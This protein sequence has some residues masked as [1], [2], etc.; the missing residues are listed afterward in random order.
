MVWEGIFRKAA[1]VE[2][3]GTDREYLF[4]VAK[5]RYVGHTFEV[6]GIAVHTFDQVI[7][8]HM[9]NEF[10]AKILSEEQSVMRV[11]VKLISEA[12]RSF[13]ALAR[14]IAGPRYAEEKVVFGTTFIHRSVE[15][16]GLK[17]FPLKSKLMERIFTRY[18]QL[19]FRAVNPHAS[20]IMLTHHDTFIPRVVAMSK[21]Q[22]IRLHAPELL[23]E[24]Q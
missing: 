5:R 20:Q 3:L 7:E 11:G 19:V 24:S 10:L 12:K 15:K 21:E 6:D 14:V 9:N 17:T 16:F 4:F 23:T 2:A 22:L 13:P 1:H 18:L 8:I